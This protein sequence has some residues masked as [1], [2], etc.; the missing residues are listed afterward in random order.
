[1]KF[2]YDW[3]YEVDKFLDEISLAIACRLPGRVRMWVV[4]NSTNVARDLYPDPT[5]YAGP[6]GLEYKHIYDGALR[7]KVSDP[8]WE[9]AS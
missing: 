3:R 5:G 8:R 6:D 7:R 9:I 1:V 4:V 2:R